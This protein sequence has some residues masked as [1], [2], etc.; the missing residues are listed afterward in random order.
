MFRINDNMMFTE[1]SIF[2]YD[3]IY[4]YRFENINIVKESFNSV[5]S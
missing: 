5:Q 1:N 2:M 4:V 3:R